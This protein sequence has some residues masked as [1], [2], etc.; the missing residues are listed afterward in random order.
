[1]LITSSFYFSCLSV[2]FEL[3]DLPLKLLSIF[4]V[5]VVVN[6]FPEIL[7]GSA[8]QVHEADQ[9]ELECLLGLLYRRVISIHEDSEDRGEERRQEEACEEELEV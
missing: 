3:I 9:V 2:L 4:V 6:I 7:Y 1:M 8:V 5:K